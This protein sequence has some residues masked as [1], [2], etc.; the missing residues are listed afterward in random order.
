MPFAAMAAGWIVMAAA[1]LGAGYALAAGEAVARF[2]ARKPRDTFEFLPVTVLK[3]LHRAEP[4]LRE[5]L[6]SFFTQEYAAPMQIVFG[7]QT[8][9]DTAIPIVKELMARYPDVDA[10][11]VIG[12]VREGANP[13][14]ANLTGMMPQAKHGILVL[15]DSDISVAPDY[16]RRIARTLLH[17]GVGAV[18]CCYAGR[19]RAGLWSRLVAQ[20]ID[21]HFLPGVIAG[22]ALGLARPCFGSTIALK[23][24]V[25]DEIG[26]FEAFKDRLADDYEIGFAIRELGYDVAVP[27]FVV[28][29]SC[30]EATM[31]E[32][33]RHELRWARTIRS[34]DPAGF[35]GSGITHALPLGVIAAALLGFSPLGLMALLPILTA[36]VILMIRIDRALS[37]PA[38]GYWLFPLRDMLSFAVFVAAF[39]AARVDWRGHRFRVRAD[40]ELARE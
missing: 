8:S 29:H 4:G 12:T 25:L 39:F 28:T 38:T 19:P 30:S 17:P 3:P 33:F 36:R 27:P 2:F 6:E 24:G 40:G 20:G 9:D 18:T 1:L 34:V 22:M 13:K 15:S 21:Y 23:R 37:R 32:F 10:S 11:L 14:I 35:A 26:G 31:T 16:L 5:N 7:V